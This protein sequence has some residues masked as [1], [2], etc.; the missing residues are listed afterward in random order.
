[1]KL[2]LSFGL[3]LLAIISAAGQNEIAPITE[4]QFA[5]KDWTLKD[6][7]TEKDVNLRT[8]AA[9]KKLV[10]VVYWAPWCPNWKYDVDFVKGLYAKYKGNGL[11][12]IGVAE[13]DPL[14]SMRSHIK[15]F[16]LTFPSVYES[17]DRTDRE[18]TEHFKQRREAGDARKWGSPWYVFLEPSKLLPVNQPNLTNKTTVINGEMMRA[19]TEKFIREKLGLPS[20]DTKAAIGKNAEIEV[21]EPDKKIGELIKP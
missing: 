20:V 5:Y 12:I 6:V 21:C 19:E 1:M 4:K 13:Y 17:T 2:F 10:M 3:V 11:E 8:S 9:G 15:Q 14:D 16:E 7:Q 18:K